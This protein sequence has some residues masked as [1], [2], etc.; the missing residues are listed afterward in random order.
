MK[1]FLEIEE[2]N[3]V[4]VINYHPTPSMLLF[5]H[6]RA[7]PRYARTSNEALLDALGMK[8]DQLERWRRLLDP[9]FSEWLDQTVAKISPANLKIAL[10]AVGI[11]KALAGEFV[12]WKPLAIREKVISPDQ[13]NVSVIPSNLSGYDNLNESN[14]D[15]VRNALLQEAR[16]LEDGRISPMAQDAGK[17]PESESNSSRT[18][19]VSEESVVLDSRLGSY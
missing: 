10:E 14:I 12:F 15:G 3:G 9:H 2:R 13:T 6:A 11:E 5:A 1:P 16:S 8:K 17:G 19:E 7:N 4:E 18:D